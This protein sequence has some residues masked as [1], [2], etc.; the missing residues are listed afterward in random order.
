MPSKEPEQERWSRKKEQGRKQGEGGG[1]GA[2]RGAEAWGPKKHQKTAKSEGVEEAKADKSNKR[3]GEQDR[4]AGKE[5]A[6]KTG[7]ESC[8][9]Q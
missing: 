1:G 2:D 3:A 4:W 9:T 7:A 6:T 5:A 8:S